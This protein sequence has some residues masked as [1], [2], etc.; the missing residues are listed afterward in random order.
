MWI[1]PFSSCKIVPTSLTM[2]CNCVMTEG[3]PSVFVLHSYIVFVNFLVYTLSMKKFTLAFFLLPLLF[4]L[5]CFADFAA[6]VNTSTLIGYW[7]FDESESGAAVDSSGYGTSLDPSGTPPTPSATAA[8]TA[9]DNPYS[10]SFDGVSSYFAATSTSILNTTTSLSIAV[11]VK[12]NSVSS[13][14]QTIV[15]KWE[16]GSKQQFLVQLNNNN[17]IGFWTGN[18]NSVGSV[19][20]SAATVSPNTWY[21]IVATVN[22]TSKNL[23]VNGILSNSGTSTTAIGTS[24]IEFT[25]G[26]K[27]YN[28]GPYFE[29]LN[30]FVDDLRLYNRVI[31]GTEITALASGSHTSAT[32]TA[33]ANTS[34]Y[35]TAANWNTGAIP[36]PYTLVTIPSAAYMPKTSA[37]TTSF[38]GLTINATSTFDANGSVMVMNDS[39]TF[40]NYGTLIIH[41]TERMFMTNDASHGA[42]M[43]AATTST[44]T[45]FG[46]TFYD[47]IVNDGLLG[48]WQFDATSTGFATDT[49]GYQLHGTPIGSDGS[50]NLPQPNASVPTTT[51]YDTGSVHF[52]GTDDYFE[53][54]R[55]VPQAIQGNAAKMVSMWVYPTRAQEGFVYLGPDDGGSDG[56]SF[57]LQ[58]DSSRKLKL[59]VSAMAQTSNLTLSLNTWQFIAAGWDGT[60]WRVCL[61]GSCEVLGSLPASDLQPGM[62]NIGRGIWDT[63][64]MQGSLDDVRLYNRMLATSTLLSMASGNVPVTSV[65]TSTVWP[66]YYVTNR[67]FILNAGTH[68]G[69]YASHLIG[70]NFVN[71][72]GSMAG[73]SYSMNLTHA[74]LINSSISLNSVTFGNYTVTTTLTFAAGSTL[75]ANS[76]WFTNND[77]GGTALLRSTVSGRQFNLNVP[78]S[79]FVAKYLDFQDVNNT[80][81]STTSLSGRFVTNSGNNSG[82]FYGLA[83]ITDFSVTPSS[84]TAILSWSNPANPEFSYN[85]IRRSTGQAPVENYEGT[86]VEDNFTGT[87]TT[88]AGLSE[89]RHYFSIFTY[90]IY[91]GYALSATTSVFIDITAPTAPGMPTTTAITSSTRPVISWDPSTDSG[92]GLAGVPYFLQWSTSTDFSAWDAQ[93]ASSTTATVYADLSDGT[94]YFLISALDNN[95]NRSEYVTSSAVIV[96]A[97]G[98][99]LTLRG[100]SVTTLTQNQ[101]YSDSGAL[102]LDAREG[103]VTGSVQTSGAVN[104]AV[105]GIY[106]I[107]Y[108]ATDGVGNSTTRTR[109]VVVSAVNSG[110]GAVSI[111]PSAPLSRDGKPGVLGVSI[112]GQESGD[113]KTDSAALKLSFNGSIAVKGVA[114]SLTPD[115]A[116]V[117][118]LPYTSEKTLTLPKPGTYTIYVKY[119]SVTGAS[120]DV[121]TRTV[122]YSSEKTAPVG[123][124][125]KTITRA[126]YNFTRNL[127]RGSQGS[128]VKLLQQFLNSQGFFVAKT[129]PG[130]L[131]KETTLYGLATEAAV[132][133]FQEAHAEEILKP[134]GLKKGTGAFFGSTR[135][136]ANKM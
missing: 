34:D 65:A 133:R 125:A 72:G 14:Y 16:V 80:N 103:D 56:Q 39:G 7:K 134:F 29:F 93:T 15:G 59:D 82:W 98:P 62:F 53:I 4:G 20:E 52:D 119:Y 26:S 85:L 55:G 75:T 124:P 78:T 37:A 57:R 111:A 54:A 44:Y 130:S 122:V 114:I 99:V 11:W 135:A 10:A 77:A 6:A 117:G 33:G 76:L 106:T 86:L 60:V 49:S 64:Y 136:V 28:G 123:S 41:G 12:F 23:Y 128:D 2:A 25:V 32:W 73:N 71:N 61:N 40:T 109:T 70:R 108:T 35:Q 63:Q 43:M 42:V 102:A 36:D 30:G 127:K 104:T 46:Y 48:Y 92:S 107:T 74:T 51:F 24:T 118:I 84:T 126:S 27:K 88:S 1:Y 91:G 69:R 67:D 90:D 21:H 68:E 120:S 113:I 96:D 83:S 79:S 5:F 45:N 9:F 132:K 66:S 95:L 19:L 50:N 3:N 47:Y 131:G 17:K 81:G 22:G 87:S 8:V 129:G 38:A 110:G 116:G 18:G 105:P 115:F 97:T 112:N 100:D 121:I 94:W 89:E 101:S 13:S 31:S 58:T